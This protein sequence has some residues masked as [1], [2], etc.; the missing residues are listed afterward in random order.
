[1]KRGG[2]WAFGETNLA[3]RQLLD[4]PH[5][6]ASCISRIGVSGR[7]FCGD[8]EEVQRRQSEEEGSAKL[9]DEGF[10]GDH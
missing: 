10:G 5:Q 8:G 4:E 3:L 2:N 1:M 6:H 9:E 7:I